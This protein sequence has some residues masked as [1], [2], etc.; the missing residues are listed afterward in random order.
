MIKA[1]APVGQ[2]HVVVDAD[3]IDVG[4]CPEW[5]E[6][7]I[8]VAAAIAGMM[9][10]ILRPIGGIADLGPSAEDRAHGRRE[11]FERGDGGIA[12]GTGADGGQTGHLRT[13]QESVHAA[14]S[15]AQMRIMQDHPAQRP[16]AD[17]PDP[18]DS[19]VGN[20]EIGW[21][22]CAEQR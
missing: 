17:R 8:H 11:A 22:C 15:F 2:R 6:M 5:I 18:T 12:A 1:V 10:E 14:C 19:F 3:E 4:I 9:A 21:G 20:V 16:F 13:D 7:E